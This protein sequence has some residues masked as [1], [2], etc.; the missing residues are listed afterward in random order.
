M[1]DKTEL[2]EGTDKIISGAST[3]TSAGGEEGESSGRRRGEPTGRAAMLDKLRSSREKLASQAAD[4][5]R[6]L[7]T[8][9]LE[10][11]AKRWPTSASWSATPP[12]ASMSAWAPN[13]ATMPAAPRPPSTTPP[14]ASPTRTPTN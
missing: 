7:V 6:G 10:K 4:K 3:P 13:M 14:T 11:S 1:D 12:T 8:Q 2:P 5:T 9:G